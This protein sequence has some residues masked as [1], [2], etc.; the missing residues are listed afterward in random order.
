[1]EVP[2]YIIYPRDMATPNISTTCP[3]VTAKSSTSIKA[4]SSLHVVMK[5][6]P[7]ASKSDQGYKDFKILRVR[8]A[9]CLILA[10]IITQDLVGRLSSI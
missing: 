5:P 7:A 6:S 8:L 1:M 2:K 3:I 9:D 10:R 4:S